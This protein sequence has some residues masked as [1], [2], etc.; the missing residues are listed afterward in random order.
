[1]FEDAY[2]K[3]HNMKKFIY[4]PANLEEALAETVNWAEHF[5]KEFAAA[6][7]ETLPWLKKK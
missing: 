2:F 6:Q 1:M 7:R 5:C 4:S 3:H